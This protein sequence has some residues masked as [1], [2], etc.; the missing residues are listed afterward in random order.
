MGGFVIEMSVCLAHQRSRSQ[1]YPSSETRLA[2]KTEF[3]LLLRF[4]EFSCSVVIGAQM[5]GY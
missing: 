1:P 5:T 4:L 3:W 2:E